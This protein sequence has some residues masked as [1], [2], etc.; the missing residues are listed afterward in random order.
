[1]KKIPV[2]NYFICKP[3]SN[4]KKACFGLPFQTPNRYG[5]GSFLVFSNGLDLPW[6]T[7]KRIFWVL[8]RA[9]NV[10]LKKKT[11]SQGTFHS[12]ATILRLKKQSSQE[13]FRTGKAKQCLCITP[14][15]WNVGVYEVLKKKPNY[16][17]RQIESYAVQEAVSYF[18][19]VFFSKKR[20]IS[21][22]YLHWHRRYARR[23]YTGKGT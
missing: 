4:A 17:V 14:I 22:F 1:M 7:K 21:L 23:L 20:T 11:R 6:V 12:S 10:K 19:T 8:D 15:P 18:L 2:K 5:K 16:N 9:Y 3:I 13:A